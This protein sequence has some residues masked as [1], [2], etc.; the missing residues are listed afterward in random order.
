MIL[1]SAVATLRSLAA[2][3]TQN[4]NTK[5]QQ[6]TAGTYRHFCENCAGKKRRCNGNKWAADVGPMSVIFNGHTKCVFS[7]LEIKAFTEAHRLGEKKR[8]EAFHRSLSYRRIDSPT[9]D[10]EIR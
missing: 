2:S 3:L 6:T 8:R 1:D 5:K 7:E 10:S 4:N 9:I